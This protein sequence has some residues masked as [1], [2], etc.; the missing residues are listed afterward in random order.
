[1]ELESTS[2]VKWRIKMVLDT[3]FI[4]ALSF[5]TFVIFFSN[6]AVKFIN[7]YTKDRK[8]EIENRIKELEEIKNSAKKR[9]VK[10]QN[11]KSRNRIKFYK[12]TADSTKYNRGT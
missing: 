12:P 5:I 11:Q 9:S 8:E 6:K 7:N 2:P 10:I 3:A 4:V 1:M